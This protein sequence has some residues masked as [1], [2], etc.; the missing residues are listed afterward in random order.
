MK[1][2]YV[3]FIILFIVLAGCRTVEKRTE[4]TRIDKHM[5]EGIKPGVT[6]KNAILEIFGYPSKTNKLEDGGEELIYDYKEKKISVYL[7]GFIVNEKNAPTTYTTLEIIIK[8]DIVK[9]Y[10][11][12]KSSE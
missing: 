12:L 6:T 3:I 8:D 11:F 2:K 4:G 5:V 10:K 7:E 9:G 1:K